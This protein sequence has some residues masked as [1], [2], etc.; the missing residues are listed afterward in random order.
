[1]KERFRCRS[2]GRFVQAE[3]LSAD[4]PHDDL[5]QKMDFGSNSMSLISPLMS[6]DVTMQ[7]LTRSVA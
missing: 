7:L 4:I 6:S 1:M 3:F 2:P 5:L